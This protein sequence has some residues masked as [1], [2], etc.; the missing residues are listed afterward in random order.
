MN[1]NGDMQLVDSNLDDIK[2]KLEE[3][4]NITTASKTIGE[5]VFELFEKSY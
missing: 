3:T 2:T 1:S 5:F 4:H